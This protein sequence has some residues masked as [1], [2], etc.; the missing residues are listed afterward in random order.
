MREGEPMSAPNP[1]APAAH[2]RTF[3]RVDV[4]AALEDAAGEALAANDPLPDTLVATAQALGLTPAEL[5][6]WIYEEPA[7]ADWTIG[8]LTAW[9]RRYALGKFSER[10]SL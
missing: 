7:R 2:W 3:D 4:L 8:A 5:R 1:I 10:E 6:L 9:A